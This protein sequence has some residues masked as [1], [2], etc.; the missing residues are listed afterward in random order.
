MSILNKL[1]LIGIVF[2]VGCGSMGVRTDAYSYKDPLCST[3]PIKKI[4]VYANIQNMQYRD[5]I[6]S[7]F[8]DYFIRRNYDCIAVKSS[9]IIL[10]TR[11]YTKNELQEIFK[12]NNIDAILM[13]SVQDT[14][15]N[16]QQFTYNQ[17]YQTYGNIYKSGSNSYNYNA[18]TYGGSQTYNFYKP[19]LNATADLYDV[20]NKS[21]IWTVQL[22]SYGNA[23]ANIDDTLNDSIKTTV[24]KLE[25]DGIV[26]TRRN[27]Y[28]Y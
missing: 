1:Y 8:I 5:E 11:S 14:G 15:Y 21:K 22:N 20:S 23:F 10:P 3:K 4:M 26:K 25:Q 16:H 27:S 24:L 17:P 9:T 7:A 13:F 19:Y 18:Y 12:S 2:I 6:E 28:N